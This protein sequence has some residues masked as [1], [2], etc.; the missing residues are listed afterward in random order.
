MPS[1][2]DYLETCID[3]AYLG[4]K[5]TLAYFN[6]GVDVE[7]KSNDTPVTIA[8]KEAELVIRERIKRDYSSHSIIGEEGGLESGDAEMRWIMTRSMALSPL[9]VVCHSTA[10]WLPS[11]L[12]GSPVLARYICQSR[13]KCCMPLRA[14]GR[15]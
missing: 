10:R 9:F 6:T 4:G 8:D 1:L 7:T 11:R 2:R 3:A 15:F 14:W 12:L 5:R 13:T